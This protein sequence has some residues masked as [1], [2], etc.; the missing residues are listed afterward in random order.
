VGKLVFVLREDHILG[1]T[2]N[3]VLGRVWKQKETRENCILRLF[4][5]CSEMM[6]GES[7]G[8][9]NVSGKDKNPYTIS[10]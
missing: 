1:T 5:M 3:R 6:E 10:D 7:A 4:I 2:T 9:E 8:T